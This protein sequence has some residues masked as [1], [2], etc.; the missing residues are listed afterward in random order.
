MDKKTAG[1]AIDNWKLK[2]FEDHLKEAGFPEF[3]VSPGLTSDM[4]FI[5]VEFDGDQLGKISAVIQ[6]ANLDCARRKM[7]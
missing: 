7:N 5:T 6:A 3:N 1:I 2:V 4:L